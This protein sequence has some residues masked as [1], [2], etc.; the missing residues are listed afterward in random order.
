MEKNDHIG[1][2]DYLKKYNVYL[3]PKRKSAPCPLIH[4]FCVW[5]FISLKNPSLS[6]YIGMYSAIH[7]IMSWKYRKRTNMVI[8]P[9]LYESLGLTLVDLYTY[10]AFI[11]FKEFFST[12]QF[13][14]IQSTGFGFSTD[15]DMKSLQ[16]WSQRSDFFLFTEVNTKSNQIHIM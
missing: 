13:L 3:F 4:S 15:E 12:V 10:W 6:T 9:D 2:L 8:S 11:H 14:D 1:T 5:V 7:M 16:T